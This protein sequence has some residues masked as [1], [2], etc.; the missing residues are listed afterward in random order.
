MKRFLTFLTILLVAFA[1]VLPATVQA[2]PRDFWAK[3]YSWT[4]GRTADGKLELTEVTSGITYKVLATDSD[5]AETLYYY[6]N[7]A[8]TS[9]TNPVTTTNYESDSI[10]RDRVQFRTDPTDSDDSTVDLIVVNTDGGYTTFF[11]DFDY[12]EHHTIIID[13]RPGLE[14]HGMIWFVFTG[15]S[16]EIDTGINFQ[17]DTLIHDVRTETVTVD[18]GE[19]ISVGIL[20]SGTGGDADGFIDARS[21]ATAGYTTD[22]G[23]ITTGPCTDYYPD[24]T[25]GDLLYT[26]LAGTTS[27]TYAAGTEISDLSTGGRT[28]LGHIVLSANEQSLTYTCSTG[29]DTAA[30]YIHYWFTRMR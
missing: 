18:A 2:E 20:S 30:G 24:S 19:D 8:M 14:H 21:V 15:A 16:A 1:F 3:V 29:S 12:R 23:I 25:Y 17:Y 13:Q 4:G 28:Y 11:E 22:T 10:S 5:T 27:I 9:L 26:I 6:D 7:Q